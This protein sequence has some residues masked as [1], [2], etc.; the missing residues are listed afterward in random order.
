MPMPAFM[1]NTPG[2]CSRPSRC[3]ERHLRR[4][5]RPA[6][7]CRSGRAAG[8]AVRG[9]RR[10]PP[11][12]AQQVIAAIGRARRVT[13]PPIA[14]SRA[15]SS[16]PQRSTAALSVVGDSRRTSAS[17]VSSQPRRAGRGRN[18]GGRIIGTCGL[19]RWPSTPPRSTPERQRP[20]RTSGSSGHFASRRLVRPAGAR[21]SAV[22]AA[23]RTAGASG[24]RTADSD[25]R[26]RRSPRRRRRS[27]PRRSPTARRP[28][29]CSACRSIPGAQFIASYDAGRGQRYYIFGSPASFVD[30]VAYYRTVLKQK[31][32]AGLRR[33]RDPRVRRRQV[34]RRHDGV[35][36]GRDDQ[37]LPV[38]RVAGLSEPEAGRPARAV[39]DVI[40]IVPVTEQHA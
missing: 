10:T 31:G 20:R 38:G 32:R 11:N 17:I 21:A 2:P 30:L 4:A 19:L 12:S 34:P 22:S 13:R 9:L 29:R 40:Q 24:A 27:R 23:W 28:K 25:H 3:D 15:A 1:S 18:S 5:D 14:S 7:R 26:R 16:A 6:R 36:A 37:G 8:L 33:A 39:P 35:S